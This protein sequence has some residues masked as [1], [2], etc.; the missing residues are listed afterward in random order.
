MGPRPKTNEMDVRDNDKTNTDIW[1]DS[2]GTQGQATPQIPTKG[3]DDGA[4]EPGGLGK[5][6]TT[7]GLEM[8][9]GYMP[10]DLMAQMEVECASIRI[11]NRNPYRWDGIGD[12]SRRRHLHYYRTNY[13]T[14]TKKPPHT[15]GQD[16]Q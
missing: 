13:E 10:L 16:Y 3:T 2:L 12:C 9:Y 14:V 1:S 5:E 8:L 4:A 7:L 6:H 11:K 15:S